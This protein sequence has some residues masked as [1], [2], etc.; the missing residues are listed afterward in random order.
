MYLHIEK[1]ASKSL[2]DVTTLTL[3]TLPAHS[4][5]ISTSLES[6]CKMFFFFQERVEEKSKLDK[7][8]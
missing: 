3:H 4:I 7:S 1:P 2:D 5:R 6:F 8:W